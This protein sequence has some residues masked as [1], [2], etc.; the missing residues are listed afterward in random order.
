MIKENRFVI[1]HQ[2]LMWKGFCSN[3]G[4]Q[5]TIHIIQFEHREKLGGL[6]L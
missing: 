5:A 1:I 2:E 3:G 4:H 6:G